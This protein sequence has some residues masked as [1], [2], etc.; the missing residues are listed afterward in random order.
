[1]D[2]RSRDLQDKI[3]AKRRK[4]GRGGRR[5]SLDD[6]QKL[7]L[8]REYAANPAA[9]CRSLAPK[10]GVSPAT[11]WRALKAVAIVLVVLLL[12]TNG[13]ASGG[14][15]VLWLDM[16]RSQARVLGVMAT[17]QTCRTVARG[18]NAMEPEDSMFAFVCRH[19]ARSVE[20]S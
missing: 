4:G 8:K 5:A 13:W 17:E 19:E 12:S 2:K 20:R 3:D 7:E 10:Y 6:A 18:L 14:R 15:K 1:M 11:I 16:G 9:S